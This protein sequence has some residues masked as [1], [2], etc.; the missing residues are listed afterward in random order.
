MNDNRK[1]R[2]L[3]IQ[4][5]FIGDAILATALV[6]KLAVSIPSCKIDILVR[7]GNEPIFKHNPQVNQLLVWDKSKHKYRELFRLL[8]KI[9]RTRYDIVINAQRFFTTGFLT[10]FSR[11]QLKIGFRKNPW[12]RFFHHRVEHSFDG[13]HEIERNQRLIAFL[14]D[15]VPANPKI[16]IPKDIERS[17]AELK[18]QPYICIAPAS[19]WF[20]KQ[21]PTDKWIEFI[22]QINSEYTIYLVGSKQDMGICETIALSVPGKKLVNLAGKLNLLQSATLMKDAVMNYV[23][24]S[25]PLHLCSATNAPVT[26]VFCSTVPKFG[27][28]PLSEKSFVVEISE[29]L[30]C[31]PCGLHGKKSCPE[32]HFQCAYGIQA[33]QLLRTLSL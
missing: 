9:R 21:Y 27:F 26:A 14:T 25:A 13:S 1:K 11:A 19:V 24:D 7:K 10:A 30:A 28:G 16:Y 18:V 15:N 31:R 23:N 6:N 17:I 33:K 12:S 20:T 2:I 3:I 5:A 22:S 8:K 29:P 32:K 4:T